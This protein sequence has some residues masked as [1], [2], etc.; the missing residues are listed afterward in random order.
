MIIK[1]N[2]KSN[3]FPLDRDLYHL[4]ILVYQNFEDMIDIIFKLK[5]I[6][7]FLETSESY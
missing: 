5:R 7:V 1:M 2:I 3:A 6:I 4:E